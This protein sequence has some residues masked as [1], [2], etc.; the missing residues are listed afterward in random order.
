[1]NTYSYL[2]SYRKDWGSKLRRNATQCAVT[3]MKNLHS[4]SKESRWL[5][6]QHIPG[7]YETRSLIT[8]LTRLIS[9]PYTEPVDSSSY[10]N[11]PFRYHLYEGYINPRLKAAQANKFCALTPICVF[12]VSKLSMSPFWCLE[13]WY[14]FQSFEKFVNTWHILKMFSSLCLA[15]PNDPLFSCFPTEVFI[16]HLSHACYVTHRSHFHS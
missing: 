7:F 8:F 6:G 1:M 14:G 16:D 5:A 2:F 3:N 9:W 4:H 11:T 13:V 15:F 10:P 12:L